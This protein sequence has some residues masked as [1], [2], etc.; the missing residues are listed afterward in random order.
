MQ[1]KISIFKDFKFGATA[2]WAGQKFVW[3]QHRSLLR[4]CLI[5]IGLGMVALA[6]G[7]WLFGAYYDPLLQWMWEKPDGWLM[8]SLWWVFRVIGVLVLFGTTLVAS[9]LVYM[10]LC[11]PFNDMLSERVEEIEGTFPVKPFNIKFVVA[12]AG[13]SILLELFKVFRKLLWLTPLFLFSLFVPIVGHFLYVIIGVYKM[14][15][16]LGMDYVDWALAR[17]GYS[18]AQRVEFAGQ[19]HWALRGFGLVMTGLSM[20]PVFGILLWPGAVAGG[21]LLCT[22]LVPQDRR[23]D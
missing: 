2:F 3:G 14:A 11:S 6:V 15:T 13:H 23:K 21:T 19:H 16:W 9:Y 18:V 8:Q 7:M 10:I 5:P 22:G 12:D 17:R 1:K 4:Y 20:I